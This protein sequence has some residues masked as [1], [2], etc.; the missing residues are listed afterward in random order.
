MRRRGYD[1]GAIWPVE[2]AVASEVA[3][4]R[5]ISVG[6]TRIVALTIRL[7]LEL[8]DAVFG[9]GKNCQG[10]RQTLRDQFLE[11]M[12]CRGAWR[13]KIVFAITEKARPYPTMTKST[14]ARVAASGAT[15]PPSLVP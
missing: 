14:A 9:M 6:V 15:H 10:D 5:K 11:P 3:H 12:G 13:F 1:A 2:P 7:S 4:H 8:I